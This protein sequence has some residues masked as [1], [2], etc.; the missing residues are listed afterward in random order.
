MPVRAKIAK[1]SPT[2]VAPAG[3]VSGIKYRPPAGPVVPAFGPAPSPLF[4]LGERPGENEYKEGRPFI[5]ESGQV[6]A[7]WFERAELSLDNFRMWNTVNDFKHGNPEPLAWE[8]D[9]DRRQVYQ[10]IVSCQPDVIAAVGAHA[11][12]WLLGPGYDLD[13]VHGIPIQWPADPA[14]TVVPVYHPANSF[15]KIELAAMGQADIAT[16]ARVLRGVQRPIHDSH[17]RP[18]YRDIPVADEGPLIDPA[19]EVVGPVSIDTEG[20]VRRPWCLSFTGQPGWAGVVRRDAPSLVEFRGELDHFISQG[21]KVILHNSMW[22]LMVLRGLGVHLPPGSF[23]DTMVMAYLLC[24]EPQGLKALAYR[25]AGMGMSSYE[26]LVHDANETHALI[27]ILQAHEIRDRLPGTEPYLTM[28]RV[29]GQFVPKIKKPWSLAR[30]LDRL[31]KDLNQDKPVDVRARW[32]KMGD[33]TRKDTGVDIRDAVVSALGPMPE[34]TLDDVPLDRA[35]HYAA[36]D[37]DAT[38]RIYPVL[39]SM[40]DQNDQNQILGIDLGAIPMFER[41]QANGFKADVPHFRQLG[42]R[43]VG[44]MERLRADVK[45]I[46]GAEINPNSP[47]QVAE[48]LFDQLG[49]PAGKKTK[50]GANSTND[51]VLEAMRFVHPVM[52][53]ILDYRECSKIKSSFCDPL[54]YLTGRDGRIRGTIKVTRVASGRPSMTD[55]NLLAQP[56]RSELGKELRRGFVAEDGCVLG[57]WDL[58]QIEMCEMGHQSEDPVLCALLNDPDKDAHSETA[59]LMFGIPLHRGSKRERYAEV[60]EIR[61]R[62]PAKRV[63][64]GVITGITGIGL[65]DQMAIANATK[66]GLAMGQGG[67]PWTESDCDLLIIEWFKIY[68]RVKTYMTGCRQE[69]RQYGYVRDRWGRIRYLPGIYSSRSWIREEAE[70]QSHSHKISSSAQGVM[71]LAMRAIWDFVLDQWRKPGTTHTV[72]DTVYPG[73]HV[74]PIIQIYDSLV[75][76]IEDDPELREYWNM[77]MVNCLTQTTTMRVPIKCKGGW[78][79]RWGG[80]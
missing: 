6:L 75:F 71:K 59:A 49:L 29:D 20:S 19:Q 35:I 79:Y 32:H 42:A 8:L 62:Y 56:V 40:I 52:P 23:I 13:T 3:S 48:L 2:G 50:G 18:V 16:V 63:G 27:Y 4:I 57:D 45:R 15:Y 70:R 7:Q 24:L 36:R 51:K 64:F 76:E 69:A 60:D 74:E 22:D 26:E 78:S 58:S 28:Q 55:P 9:R 12:R 53:F 38:L 77:V 65:K 72:G 66:N 47:V 80:D 11:V 54:A 5:G 1:S 73:R 33:K 31:V 10:E 14:I 30:Y 67:D 46:T 34:A 43:M 39:Q 37:A 25:H 68:K 17:D 41:M 44:E 61:H 21:G